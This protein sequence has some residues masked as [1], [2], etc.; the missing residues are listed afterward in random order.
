MEF[1]KEAYEKVSK[2]EHDNSVFL[3]S[4]KNLK[5]E[6]KRLKNN[7]VSF[8]N[9]L[10][11][12]HFEKNKLTN[13]NESLKQKLALLNQK[14]I[15]YQE[16]LNQKEEATEKLKEQMLK[17]RLQIIEG[18]QAEFISSN[19]PESFALK[20]VSLK[21]NFKKYSFFS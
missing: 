20:F 18:L 9:A 13:E 15:Q 3:E 8:N 11:Q 17:K 21:K 4:L 1:K 16:E 19:G 12:V 10:S 2:M 5:F 6:N 7:L 14:V